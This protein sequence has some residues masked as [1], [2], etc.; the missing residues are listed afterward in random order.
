[1]EFPDDAGTLA[2][3]ISFSPFVIADP[4]LLAINLTILR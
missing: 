2:M 3:E 4:T 1:M